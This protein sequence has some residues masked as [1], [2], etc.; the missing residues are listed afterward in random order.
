M[1]QMTLNNQVLVSVKERKKQEKDFVDGCLNIFRPKIIHPG[2]W[3]KDIPENINTDI[4]ISRMKD[5]IR[6]NK[7]ASKIETL[8]YI[9][10]C[11]LVAP[12]DHDFY[13]IMMF[14]TR[15]WMIEKNKD[16]PD[17]LEEEIELTEI[18]EHDLFKLREWIYK[19]GMEALK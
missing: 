15:E 14:L 3:G 13:N 6:G 7:L 5:T 9:S 16:L 8:W 10:S 18:Q 12:L 1:N 11:S 4:L 2:G 17:F 19:K